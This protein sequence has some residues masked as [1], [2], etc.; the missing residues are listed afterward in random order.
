MQ[1]DEARDALLRELDLLIEGVASASDG[2]YDR[3]VR[4][5]GWRVSDLLQHVARAPAAGAEGLRR[6]IAGNAE[7]PAEP[8]TPPPDPPAI[9]AALAEGRAEFA[10]ALA[11]VTEESL[12]NAFPLYFITVP[13]VAALPLMLTEIG[14]HR[15]DLDWALGERV[16]LPAAV[17][18]AETFLV[19]L[20]LLRVG[21][22]APVRPPTPVSYRLT[23]SSFSFT[24]SFSDGAWTLGE[25]D[26]VSC[27]IA[28]DDSSVLLFALGRIRADD[29]T[30]KVVGDK[31][32]ARAFKTYLPGP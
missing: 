5:D 4:C 17:I 21:Q 29:P 23:G 30:L 22:G 12:A 14:T 3:P 19:P 26:P 20:M 6:M 11:A 18:E 1:L 32:L 2:D 25:H 28:G 15:N 13:G 8:A 16:P 27:E 7:Q 31:G 10:P 24:L 9:A